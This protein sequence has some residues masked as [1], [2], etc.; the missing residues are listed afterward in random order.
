M[1][2]LLGVIFLV[3][4][5]WLVGSSN[6]PEGLLQLL[7]GKG[8]YQISP[9]RTRL[10]GLLIASPLPVTKLVKFILSDL[11]GGRFT[12]FASLFEPIYFLA[13]LILAIV[14]AWRIRSPVEIKIQ[15]TMSNKEN[16]QHTRSYAKRFFIITG[17][18][19]T[20]IITLG[21][22]FILFMI[23]YLGSIGMGL[24]MSG[25]FSKDFLPVIV[26]ICFG[27]FGSIM[28]LRLLKE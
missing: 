1:L 28:L 25:D 15:G 26:I 3:I 8:N 10:F 14:I 2:F 23:L 9:D 12:G 18:A 4:G 13:V 21:G 16:L 27:L 20:S 19:L 22:I 24:A 5:L 11:I 7:F 17:L 6:P